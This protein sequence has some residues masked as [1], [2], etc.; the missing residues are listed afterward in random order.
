[1]VNRPATAQVLSRAA[2]CPRCRGELPCGRLDCLAAQQDNLAGVA[3]ARAAL[4]RAIEDRKPVPR[5]S[6]EPAA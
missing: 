5:R 3:A 4:R 1:M 6:P 2:R